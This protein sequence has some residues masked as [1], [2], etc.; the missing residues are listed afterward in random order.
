M[1]H[2]L[3]DASSC[4]NDIHQLVVQFYAGSKLRLIYCRS[5]LWYRFF[6]WSRR[7]KGVEDGKIPTKKAKFKIKLHISLLKS[8]TLTF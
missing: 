6:Y 5:N 8:S 1:D 2:L 4:M 3:V 7:K